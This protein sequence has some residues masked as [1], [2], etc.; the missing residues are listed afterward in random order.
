M[1]SG[2]DAFSGR[3]LPRRVVYVAGRTLVPSARPPAGPL[4]YNQCSPAR[5]PLYLT[6][7]TSLLILIA[8]QDSSEYVV[9]VDNIVVSNFL[10]MVKEHVNKCVDL[11]LLVLAD[12]D[13]VE[14]KVNYPPKLISILGIFSTLKIQ[15]KP[16]AVACIIYSYSMVPISVPLI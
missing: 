9:D 16:R 4:H 3:F 2:W 1:Y 10:E 15:T 5:L 7:P 13:L 12:L 6:S 11:T 14:R 8:V